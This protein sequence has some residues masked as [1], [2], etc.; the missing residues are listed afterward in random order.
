[1]TDLYASLAELTRDLV[2]L[3]SRSSL[4]NIAVA[5][6]IEAELEGFEV[7]RIDFQDAAGVHKRVL[8]AHRG[9]PNGLA[10]SGHMD[11]V[12]DTGWQDDPWSGR[13]DDGILLGLG[14]AD[15][16]GPVAAAII[17]AISCSPAW[18]PGCRRIAR[19][20]RVVMRTG[21]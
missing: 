10:Y 16:K 21:R 6:R 9:G 20:G 19:P 12:P 15:M 7:E 4:S 5:E 11:T 2:E 14:S 8:V 13:I 3:D 18:R 17:A 1:M